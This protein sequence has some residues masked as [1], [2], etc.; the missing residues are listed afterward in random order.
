ML[1][2]YDGYYKKRMKKIF[3]SSLTIA[4]KKSKYA[5]VN[6][7]RNG[8]ELLNLIVIKKM[9]KRMEDTFLFQKEG[10]MYAWG[11][12]SWVGILS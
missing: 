3:C 1:A 11:P 7:S 10:T 2:S 5:V 12:G 8:Q 4:M 6:L 9:L